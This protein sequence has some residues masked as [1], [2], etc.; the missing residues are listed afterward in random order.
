MDARGVGVYV[1]EANDLTAYRYGSPGSP[2]ACSYASPITTSRM[3][4]F[5]AY[6]VFMTIGSL[7]EI[8]SRLMS[9]PK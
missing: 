5:F 8:Q 6:N 9:L 1:A 4:Q 2:D 3:P 7:A